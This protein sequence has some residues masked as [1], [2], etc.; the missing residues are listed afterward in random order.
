MY[1]LLFPH[2]FPKDPPIRQIGDFSKVASY[3]PEEMAPAIKGLE[4]QEGKSYLLVNALGSL[5]HWGP[6]VNGDAFPESALMSKG[7]S[8]GYKTFEKFAHVYQHHVNKDPAK[9]MG[10]VK[11]AAYN[12]VMHRVELLLEVDN[13]KAASLLEKVAAG[14]YPDWSM[15]CKVP[16]DICSNCGHQAKKVAEYC[17]HLKTAMNS[18]LDDG[19]RN[20]AINTLPKFF[21][22]SEVVVGADKTAKL[23]RK[24]ASAGSPGVSSA[25]LGLHVYGED[26]EKV[27]GPKSAAIEKDVPAESSRPLPQLKRVVEK[28]E[29]Y[30][31][32]LPKTAV[33][34][35]SSFP[36]EEVFSTLGYSGI[37]L[38]PS[39][40]QSIVL[41]KL[42]KADLAVALEKRGISFRP[43]SEEDVDWLEVEDDPAMVSPDHVKEA[44]FRVVQGFVPHRSVWEPHIHERVKRASLLGGETRRE[45]EYG[46]AK[47]AA[48]DLLGLLTGLGLSY[49][50]Y[51]KSFPTEGKAF[52]Q[53]IMK[54]PWMAPILLGATLGAV[55]VADAVLGAT[56]RANAYQALQAANVK[57]A[58]LPWKT[59]GMVV[60]PVGLAY[61]GAASAA[62]KEMTGRPLNK[63]EEILRDYPGLV[64]PA[65]AYGLIKAKKFV[66]P[67][68]K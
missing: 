20:Y 9:A 66:M 53:L 34:K 24:V 45:P 47:Q 64:G 39:E 14:E 51:R 60:G 59:L 12:P 3:C 41:R 35:L 16:Y 25:L 13:V 8:H 28:L 50:L 2:V 61:I 38:R 10:V 36:L 62:R 43:P 58:G 48:P 46:W 1:K 40:Y 67:V 18:I 19:R 4:P 29:A 5:E 63:G 11:V 65:L 44:V 37:V 27:S 17:G 23:L 42:G 49:F 52:E 68:A 56:P 57:V 21:D 33:E 54:K 30:E 55:N 6:N 15:G 22:I 32:D 31:P 26:V 7:A